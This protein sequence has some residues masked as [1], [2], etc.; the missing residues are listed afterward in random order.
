MSCSGQFVDV[1]SSDMGVLERVEGWVGKIPDDSKEL[2]VL[3]LL[4]MNTVFC[5]VIKGAC[6]C[7]YHHITWVV[8]STHHLQHSH[9]N[10]PF[11][12]SMTHTHTHM[13]Y[14]CSCG[15]RVESIA[16]VMCESPPV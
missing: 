6:L 8:K 4:F 1:Q 3:T 12:D 11:R 2:L 15:V 13:K 16:I 7:T 5:H 14:L 10:G 9:G